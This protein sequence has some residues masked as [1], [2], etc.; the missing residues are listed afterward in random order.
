MRLT[1]EQSVNKGKKQ[2]KENKGP[3]DAL[4]SHGRTTLSLAQVGFTTE[5]EM[6]SGGTQP[7][8]SP[9]LKSL[10]HTFIHTDTP[11]YLGVIESSLTA[12]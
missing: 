10:H 9:G 11:K 12:Y 2:G 4:L 8:L 7:L 6:E 1:Q 5:F 3:G